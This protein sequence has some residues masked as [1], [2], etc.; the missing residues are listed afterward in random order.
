[1][2]KENKQIVR[3]EITGYLKISY[4]VHKPGHLF[5]K[6]EE[7]EEERVVNSVHFFKLEKFIKHKT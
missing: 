2:Q 3:C 4:Q 5:L 6:E 1:M 7:E